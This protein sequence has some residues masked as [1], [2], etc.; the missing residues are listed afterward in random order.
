MMDQCQSIAKAKKRPS[1]LP[2]PIEDFCTSKLFFEKTW[3]SLIMFLVDITASSG[4]KLSVAFA[5]KLSV[6]S[7]E[8]NWSHSARFS[9]RITSSKISADK[10]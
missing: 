7:L 2:Q 9:G 8:R 10:A 6:Q 5:V 1:T 4:E 3:L